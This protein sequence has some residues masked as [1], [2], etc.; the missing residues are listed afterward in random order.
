MINITQREKMHGFKKMKKIIYGKGNNSNVL[1]IK[2]NDRYNGKKFVML[3]KS[4]K[5]IEFELNFYANEEVHPSMFEKTTVELPAGK[6]YKLE[7]GLQSVLT[8]FTVELSSVTED[9]AFKWKL[10][11]GTR[12]FVFVDPNKETDDDVMMP[13]KRER[14]N[15]IEY[16]E[17]PAERIV[18]TVP[19]GV[20]DSDDDDEFD[21]FGDEANALVGENQKKFN[22]LQKQHEWHDFYPHPSDI[23]IRDD[24]LKE[25]NDAMEEDLK[26]IHEIHAAWTEAKIQMEETE[27]MNRDPINWV[28]STQDL[29]LFPEIEP[30]MSM[31]EKDIKILNEATDMDVE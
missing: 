8:D 17:Q 9:L 1:T 26:K 28:F 27:M 25:K 16:F 10:D 3:L 19:E 6:E 5:N 14:G 30:L 4:L 31:S 7:Y 18:P 2:F 23:D 12:C 20:F 29:T 24:E 11:D 22:E 21:L 15:S 13:Q